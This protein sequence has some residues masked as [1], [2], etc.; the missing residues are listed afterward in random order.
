MNQFQSPSATQILPNQICSRSSPGF[1]LS[2]ELCVSWTRVAHNK[3]HL[4]ANT[5]SAKSSSSPPPTPTQL[6]QKR[7]HANATSHG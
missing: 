5:T 4:T 7:H 1:K 3:Q 6:G 2:Q